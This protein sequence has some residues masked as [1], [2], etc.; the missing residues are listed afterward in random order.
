MDYHF[1]GKR[2]GRNVYLVKQIGSVVRPVKGLKDFA[3][4]KL[5]AGE[6]KRITFII[7]KGKLSF[8]NQA[9]QWVAEPGDFDLMIGASSEDIRLKGSFELKKQGVI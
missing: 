3:K 1:I 9:L 5:G 6:S 2:F 4:V 7:D 8:Y